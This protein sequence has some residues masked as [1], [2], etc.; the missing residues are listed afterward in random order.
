MELEVRRHRIVREHREIIGVL[1]LV[2][3]IPAILLGVLIGG[4]SLFHWVISSH[5]I[6]TRDA[7]GF[8]E[9]SFLKVRVGM[10]IEEVGKLL[11]KPL[12]ISSTKTNTQEWSYTAPKEPFPDWGTWDVRA[13][14]VSNN[15]V[16]EIIKE[17]DENH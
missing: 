10:P 7:P 3:L 17:R 16:A 11:G 4:G 9:E 1:G 8:S 15:H 14:I 12:S 13:L 2:L 5:S 6:S